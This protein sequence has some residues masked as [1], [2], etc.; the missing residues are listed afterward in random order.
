[1]PFAKND[2]CCISQRREDKTESISLQ[3][4][5]K[6]EFFQ[7]MYF[8]YTY[9]T[10]VLS[11]QAALVASF[12][13]FIETLTLLF[14]LIFHSVD[15]GCVYSNCQNIAKLIECIFPYPLLLPHENT[16]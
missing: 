14:G 7:R 2:C 9:V 5:K 8:A 12:P 4:R 3:K 13:S 6:K 11:K 16:W 10:V 1:M 15:N